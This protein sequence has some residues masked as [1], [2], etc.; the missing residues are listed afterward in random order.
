MFFEG[1]NVAPNNNKEAKLLI[2]KTVRYVRECDIDRNRGMYF[3][4]SQ[5]FALTVQWAKENRMAVKHI[6]EK[7]FGK[8]SFVLDTVHNSFEEIDEGVIIRKGTVKLSE[9][10]LSIIP[11][12]MEDDMV[13]VKATKEIN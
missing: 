11:S 5:T 6:L 2:G 3:P 1:K 4:I 7:V 10:E 8:T 13:E 12:N 9:G